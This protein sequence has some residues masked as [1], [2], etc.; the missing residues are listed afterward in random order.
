ML[1]RRFGSTFHSVTASFDSRALSE[2]SF[3]KNGEHSIPAEEFERSYRKLSEEAIGGEAEGSVQSAVED[4]LLR[5]LETDVADRLSRLSDGEILVVENEQGV[6]Y[7]K[8]RDKKRGTIV[9][10]ENRLYFEWRV[11]PPLRLGHYRRG[12]S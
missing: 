5:Q 4:Q 2:I 12:E 11:D 7:P 8:V 3:R 9:D 1:L 10:G 6:D